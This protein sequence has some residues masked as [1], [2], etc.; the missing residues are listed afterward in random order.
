MSNQCYGCATSFK[1]S[2]LQDCVKCRRMFC[3]ECLK[4]V[5][6]EL[7]GHGESKKKQK[8]AKIC[9]SCS[10]ADKKALNKK[11]Q[12]A[13]TLGNLE[14]KYK[15]VASE[16]ATKSA[17]RIRI[18]QDKELE[19]RLKELKG[20]SLHTSPA[21]SVKSIEQ[22]LERLKAEASSN[23]SNTD[24]QENT[25]SQE[26]SVDKSDLLFPTRKTEA[27]EMQDLMKQV[28]GEAK[29]EET[30]KAMD[31]E[32]SK[33]LYNLKSNGQNPS[34]Y[35]QPPATVSTSGSAEEQ[36]SETNPDGE[37]SK[38]VSY[39]IEEHKL[40]EQRRKENDAFIANCEARLHKL[41]DEA[42][43]IAAKYGEEVRSKLP[44]ESD[45]KHKSPF[46]PHY[47]LNELSEEQL[48]VEVQK[49]VEQFA[50]EVELD[51][52]NE[53]FFGDIRYNDS[54]VQ[55]A[56]NFTK[57]PLAGEELPWCCICNDD[58]TL[59][60]YDCDD[61]LYC[62]RCFRDGHQQFHL[63]DHKY[64]AFTKPNPNSSAASYK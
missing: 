3:S 59:Q 28:A 53:Q 22:R 38:L 9:F 17:I 62:E 27:E 63:F 23:T 15:D 30:G 42:T 32:L 5:N 33:R 57:P 35:I 46:L 48:D 19:K 36:A 24:K 7:V 8:P 20:S 21:P 10:R 52:K 40:E 12:E 37:V 50:A 39:A 44:Q 43:D 61:D 16:H 2:K 26:P 18:N 29:I 6:E 64:A 54:S 14:K 41:T 51:K 47:S 13:E 34:F 56:S 49:L 4:I 45:V 1:Q 25:P 58:A 60:C 31:Q 55:F 11:Q